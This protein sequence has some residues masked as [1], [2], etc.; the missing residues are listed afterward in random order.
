M[1]EHAL[2]CQYIFNVAGKP[3]LSGSLTVRLFQFTSLRICLRVQSY[4][5]AK[6]KRLT[7]IKKASEKAISPDLFSSD[8]INR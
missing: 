6:T 5:I 1:H 4:T 2:I 3:H 8:A 7:H